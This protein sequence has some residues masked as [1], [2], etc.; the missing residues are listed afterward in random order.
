MCSLTFR[1]IE[2]KFKLNHYNLY[3][4][5]TGSNTFVQL[6]ASGICIIEFT[7]FIW[8]IISYT[9]NKSNKNNA[10]HLNM[11]WKYTKYNSITATP[12]MFALRFLPIFVSFKFLFCVQKCILAVRGQ[13]ICQKNQLMKLSR[14]RYR[15]FHGVKKS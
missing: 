1:L 6:L 9:R 2:V 15:P 5:W 3:E 10:H 12:L 8:P 14:L 11:M 13:T 4:F 7:T